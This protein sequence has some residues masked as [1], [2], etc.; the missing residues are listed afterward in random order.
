MLVLFFVAILS[1]NPAAAN[2]KTSVAVI[3]AGISGAACALKL[4]AWGFDVQ[5]YDLFAKHQY[6]MQIT[7]TYTNYVCFCSTSAPQPVQKKTKCDQDKPPRL[8]STKIK[9]TFNTIVQSNA[10]PIMLK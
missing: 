2:K 9:R 3:G 8:F 6:P 7:H 5:V 1:M 10:C 4:Q